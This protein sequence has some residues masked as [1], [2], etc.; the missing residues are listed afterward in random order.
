M[1]K[2]T[3][4]GLTEIVKVNSNSHE[5]ELIAR[6]DT[7]ATKSS[8]DLTLASELRLGPVVDSRLIKS[9]HGSKL[10]PVVEAEI[11]ICGRTIKAKFTLADRNHMRYPMLIGQ[12][13]LR[14]GFLIDP[15]RSADK[16]FADS[17]VKKE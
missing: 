15:S 9:A 14:K 2:R 8:L 3:I 6:I 10:R 12:N 5:Q 17:K 11:N 4:V 13:V 1:K 16:I 7:G